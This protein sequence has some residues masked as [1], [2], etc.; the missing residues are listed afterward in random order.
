MLVAGDE[1]GNTQ[2][3]N[4]NPYNQDNETTWLDWD[5]VRTHREL[6]DFVKGMIALRKTRRAISRSRFWRDDVTWYGGSG[7]PDLAP[8]SHSVAWHLSGAAFEEGDL[9]VMVNAY[10]ERLDFDVQ[11]PGAW[12]RIVDTSRSTGED[13]CDHDSAPE[14][15]GGP[16]PVGPRSVVVLA[17]RPA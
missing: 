10:H 14:V 7:G 4:N 1:F 9:Y 2:D 8:W 13:V 17:T 3:G 11:V 5:R 12:R 15:D 16:V 6:F